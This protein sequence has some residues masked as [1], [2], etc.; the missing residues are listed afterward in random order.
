MTVKM[1]DNLKLVTRVY[2]LWTTTVT[3]GTVS[4]CNE[5]YKSEEKKVILADEGD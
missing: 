4:A 1:T 2:V 3:E 5:I